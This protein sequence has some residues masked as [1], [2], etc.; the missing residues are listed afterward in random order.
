[1]AAA[2]AGGKSKKKKW[3]KGKSR[4]V[5]QNKVQFEEEL[6]TRFMAEV[7][8]MKLITPSALVER[9]KINASLARAAIKELEA[10]DQVKRVS[11][12]HS[13]WIY[14]RSSKED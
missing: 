1:M 5:N 3:S 13:Q 12:H 9:L 6:Y 4:D 10:N 8:K 7:P 11:Y 2:M 14:T